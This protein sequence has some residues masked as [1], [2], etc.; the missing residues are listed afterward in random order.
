ML[1][2]RESGLDRYQC[3]VSLSSILTH[4][5]LVGTLTAGDLK[6]SVD[7]HAPPAIFT[8][9][10]KL[11]CG[12]PALSL[13]GPSSGNGFG[14]G[15][16]IKEGGI[17]IQDGVR[18]LLPM[19]GSRCASM[20]HLQACRILDTLQDTC[21]MTNGYYS[22]SCSDQHPASPLNIWGLKDGKAYQWGRYFF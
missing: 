8:I 19:S 20:R 15:N 22:S 17:S 6:T 3:R 12:S 9:L 18:S 14:I 11:N 4:L 13:L 2:S 16:V 10:S 1:G 7:D 5:S 21:M